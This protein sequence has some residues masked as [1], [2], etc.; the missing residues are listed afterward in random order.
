M[1]WR[2]TERPQKRAK[3]GQRF[4]FP[5]TDEET[6]RELTTRKLGGRSRMPICSCFCAL[7]SRRNP[8]SGLAAQDRTS[9]V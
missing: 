4:C 1:V 8:P 9:C 2:V 5:Q 6:Y 7:Y 3:S